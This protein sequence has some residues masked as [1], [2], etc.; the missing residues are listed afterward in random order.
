MSPEL[1]SILDTSSQRRELLEW[2]PAQRWFASKSK[3]VTEVSL[4]DT[5]IVREL[6]AATEL[7]ALVRVEFTDGSEDLYAVP[8]EVA[9][10]TRNVTFVEVPAPEFWLTF[11]KKSLT[12]ECSLSTLSGGILCGSTTHAFDSQKLADCAVDD[13]QQHAGQQSNTSVSIGA[14]YFLKLFRRPQ[15]GLNPD[16]ELGAFLTEHGFTNSP[17]VAG[18]ITYQPPYGRAVGSE[19]CCLAILSQR[20]QSESEA[21]SYYLS[22]VDGFWRHL[23]HQP[24]RWA[25]APHPVDWRLMPQGQSSNKANADTELLGASLAAATLLG[26]RTAEMHRTLAQGVE[27]GF[28][29]EPFTTAKWSELVGIVRHEITIT[30]GLLAARQDVIAHVGATEFAAEFAARASAYLDELA[31][32]ESDPGAAMIRVH[33]DYHLGQV[34]RANDDFFIVDFEGEPDRPLA[35]RRQKRPVFKDVAG[36]LRSFHY[37]ANAGSTGLA[38]LSPETDRVGWQEY[39]FSGVARAFLMSYR[40]HVGNCG[41]LPSDPRRAQQLLDLFLLEKALYELRYELNNRP[42]WANIPITGLCQIL[43]IART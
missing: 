11:L 21:W 6:V 3:R 23:K 40:D 14:A 24:H 4:V 9:V 5:A 15:R 16:A 19:D 32:H 22:L 33:G 12:G 27:A 30:E 18:I 25:K 17:A 31:R 2:L 10:G 20:L 29:P 28:V 34:L 8:V 1:N 37:A 13:V 36:M 39:W 35:E 42:D 26:Q 38:D 41:L 43:G 7:L